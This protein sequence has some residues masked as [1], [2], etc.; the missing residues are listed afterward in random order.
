MG[1]HQSRM[2]NQLKRQEV[3]ALRKYTRSLHCF[4]YGEGSLFHLRHF[5]EIHNERIMYTHKYLLMQAEEARIKGNRTKMEKYKAEATVLEQQYIHLSSLTM[6]ANTVVVQPP[7]YTS[8]GVTPYVEL[9][10]PPQYPPLS[11]LHY[12]QRST[13]YSQSL[14]NSDGSQSFNSS[15]QSYEMTPPQYQEPQSPLSPV[16]CCS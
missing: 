14:S 6:M 2:I 1:S 12:S 3:R 5:V 15:N 11:P 4:G 10:Q 7:I 8:V 16:I 13:V 9:Q